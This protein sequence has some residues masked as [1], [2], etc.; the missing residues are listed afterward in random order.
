MFLSPAQRWGDARLSGAARPA[1]IA[2][3]VQESGQLVYV[4]KVRGAVRY[5]GRADLGS[6]VAGDGCK[7]RGGGL[8]HITGRANYAV[9]GEELGVDLIAQ[10]E[11]LAQPPH[12]CLSVAWF[13][14][15][16][17]LSTPADADKFEFITRRIN[18]GL[19]GQPNRLRLSVKASVTLA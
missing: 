4:R 11:L 13:W 7:Y 8:I 6:T 18:G 19:N 3:I 10:P 9:C 1:Y 16:K 15:T 17:G 12:A 14:A 5:E 2:Q